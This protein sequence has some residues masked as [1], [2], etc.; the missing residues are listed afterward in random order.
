MQGAKAKL[1]EV[2]QS[3]KKYIFL[4]TPKSTFIDFLRNSPLFGIKLDIQRDKNPSKEI[5]L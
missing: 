3:K 4:I 5:E 1:N 2:I